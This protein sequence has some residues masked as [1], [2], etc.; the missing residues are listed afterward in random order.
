MAL[1]QPLLYSLQLWL[2]TGHVEMV[3]NEKK[4]HSNSA[5]IAVPDWSI[6][7][8]VKRAAFSNHSFASG[9]PSDTGVNCGNIFFTLK[10]LNYTRLELNQ[11][12][13]KFRVIFHS[14]TLRVYFTGLIKSVCTSVMITNIQII[15]ITHLII[16]LHIHNTYLQIYVTRSITTVS[17]PDRPK[18]SR[19]NPG[20][21]FKQ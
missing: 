6:L 13:S 14:F 8:S 21:S 17:A 20:H 18:M 12:R 15:I 3:E 10:E 19:L 4:L 11:S 5:K 1:L 7:R 16:Q 9:R 2:S